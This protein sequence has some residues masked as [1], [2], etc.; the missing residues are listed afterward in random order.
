MGVNKAGC[1]ELCYTSVQKSF[2]VTK[3]NETSSRHSISWEKNLMLE[4]YVTN[5]GSTYC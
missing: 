2:T 1:R 3:T 4:R 5:T